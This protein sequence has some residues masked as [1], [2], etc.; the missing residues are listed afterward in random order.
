[1]ALLHIYNKIQQFLIAQKFIIQ[2]EVFKT[3]ALASFEILL[4]IQN[5]SP[6][7]RPT[8]PESVF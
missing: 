4:E 7:P 8:E 3:A 2:R 1:M 5:P 6:C